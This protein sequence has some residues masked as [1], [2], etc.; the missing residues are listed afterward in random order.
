MKKLICILILTQLLMG[1]MTSLGWAVNESNNEKQPEKQPQP[2]Y[3]KH[4]VMITMEG[5]T[6]KNISSG[7]TP[8]ISGIAGRGV[9]TSAIGV[10]PANLQAFTASFLTGADPSVHGYVSTGQQLKTKTFPEV[11]LDYGRSVA[12]I[13]GKT[14]VQ[15]ELYKNTK[16]ISI[17]ALKSNNTQSTIEKAIEVFTKDQPYFTGIY[18][19]AAGAKDQNNLQ[20]VNQADKELGQFINTLSQYGVLEQTLLIVVGKPPQTNFKNISAGKMDTLAPVVMAGPGLKIGAALPPV[21]ITD[22]TPTAAMLAGVQLPPEN[23]G[24][25]LWNAL[26]PDSGYLEENLLLKRVKDLSDDAVMRNAEVYQMTEEKRLLKL[27][28][29]KVAQEKS[30]I[31]K[32][33]QEKDSTITKLKI[34]IVAFKAAVL[35]IISVMAVGYGVEYVYLRKKF[36]MF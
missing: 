35:L 29:Q 33:I 10:L 34:Q 4:I 18:L 30:T 20:I 36:L 11:L 13:G 9:K 28:Q 22:I 21:K 16:G 3:I 19:S 23:S 26:S 15:Q 32:T 27:E 6:D 8:N 2:T 7:Y 24:L 25:V 14:M 12:L 1:M 17:H 31:Q 5:L